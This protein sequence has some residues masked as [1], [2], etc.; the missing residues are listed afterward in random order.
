[1]LSSSIENTLKLSFFK[2]KKKKKL[3]IKKEGITFLLR[4]IYIIVQE[5]LQYLIP[6]KSYIYLYIPIKIPNISTNNILNFDENEI[7]YNICLNREQIII[8]VKN[9][10]KIKNNLYKFDIYDDNLNLITNENQLTKNI[11]NINNIINNILYIKIVKLNEEQIEQKRKKF[12]LHKKLKSL[13]INECQNNAHN[14]I[15][16]NINLNNLKNLLSE[17]SILNDKE[18]E[19]IHSNKK[20]DNCL[21]YSPKIDEDKKKF[22]NERNNSNLNM[23]NKN[24][25]TED[26]SKN[27]NNKVINTNRDNN[28]N[29]NLLIKSKINSLIYNKI[30]KEEIKKNYYE[31]KK[32]NYKKNIYNQGFD[33]SLSQY[34]NYLQNKKNKI[35]FIK[36]KNIQLK[37]PNSNNQIFNNKYIN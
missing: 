23:I 33:I 12:C 18:K 34:Y 28:H 5:D 22:P 17:S 13:L 11:K 37:S 31:K 2:Q 24:T 15:F 14:N 26:L 27:T 3:L 8:K 6:S 30:K 9:I 1:M 19:K 10:L 29:N 35:K 32:N 21:N 7:K 20:Y 36:N 16:K 4:R 25:S